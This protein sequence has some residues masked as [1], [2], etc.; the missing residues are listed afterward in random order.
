MAVGRD[1]DSVLVA[2]VGW[3]RHGTWVCCVGGA[4]REVRHLGSVGVKNNMAGP[5]GGCGWKGCRDSPLSYLPPSTSVPRPRRGPHR[6]PPLTWDAMSGWRAVVA[7]CTGLARTGLVHIEL[8]GRLFRD[9]GVCCW[10]AGV[11]ATLSRSC[12]K[13]RETWW[14]GG[15]CAETIDTGEREGRDGLGRVTM[16]SR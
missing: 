9:A 7:Q 1:D 2:L 8:T 15:R 16:V 6:S 14:D 5:A 3:H 10:W 4:G 12:H 11:G 13:W